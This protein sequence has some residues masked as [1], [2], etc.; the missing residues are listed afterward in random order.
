MAVHFLHTSDW[1]LGQFF[2]NHDREF[3]HAQF[4]TWLLEQIKTKQPHAL[5]IA[6]DIFDVINPA[7]SAQR[8]LYQFLADA[9]DLAPH[10][11]TLMIAGNHDSGYRIEQVEPL[12]AKFNAKAV[13][14]VGRTAEN[15]LNLDRLLIPIYDRDKNIIAWCLTLPYLR[16]AEITGLNEHTSNNQNAISYLHQQLIAEAKARK[17][18]HQALILMSHAHMQGG[19]TSDSERPIIVGNEEALSTALFDDVIDYVALGHLHK[20]QKV[21]Q[22]HIRYSGSPIPLSFSEINYKH[23]IVEVRIDPQLEDEARFQFEAL[24]IPRSV[25]LH[26]LRGELNEIF[27]QIRTLEHGEIEAIDQ[28]EYIDIEYHTATPPPPNLR[29]TF[30]DALPPNRYRLVRISRQ[31][32]AINLDDAQAQKIHLEPP[33]PKRLFEQLWL[34]QGYSADDSVLKDFLSLIIEAEKSIDANETP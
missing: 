11:Q 12:L 18:P 13:G 16:S 26:R 7:S 31:Y 33:T 8:Q 27:E 29:Q 24:L 6:G 22:P 1:H 20:P 28:R 17:Q 5:L 32:Q 21:G 34:K 3:E 19:E 4:L 25:S 15:T 10:M 9:H 30:E 23:Q 14:I 2:H